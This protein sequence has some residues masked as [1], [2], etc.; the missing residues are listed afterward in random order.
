[1]VLPE[2]MAKTR[3]RKEKKLVWKAVTESCLCELRGASVTSC[4]WPGS[5]ARCSPWHCLLAGS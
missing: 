2:K 4:P 5:G 1:M 3:E